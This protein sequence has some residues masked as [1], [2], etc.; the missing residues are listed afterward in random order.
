MAPD[1]LE[2]LLWLFGTEVIVEWVKH[3]SLA[4]MNN[5]NASILR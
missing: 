1:I 4:K 5:L 3:I 2:K